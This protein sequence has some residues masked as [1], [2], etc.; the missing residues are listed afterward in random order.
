MSEKNILLEIARANLKIAE[1]TSTEIFE[2]IKNM[3]RMVFG[4]DLYRLELMKI[5]HA[6]KVWQEIIDRESGVTSAV[7]SGIT[8]R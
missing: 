8:R 3:D 2:S 4:Y 6:K 7:S 1:D 5:K